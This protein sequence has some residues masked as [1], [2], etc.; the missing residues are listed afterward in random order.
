M[1]ILLGSEQK[2]VTIWL[3]NSL[4][5]ANFTLSKYLTQNLVKDYLIPRVNMSP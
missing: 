4:L 3:W 5:H 2:I 1:N